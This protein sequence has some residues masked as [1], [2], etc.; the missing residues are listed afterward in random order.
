MT[1]RA[2]TPME[3]CSDELDKC[4]TIKETKKLALKYLGAC[5][6]AIHNYQRESL[7]H[8]IDQPNQGDEQ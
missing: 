6:N 1:D 5:I 7:K 8:R 4:K 2:K 3:H